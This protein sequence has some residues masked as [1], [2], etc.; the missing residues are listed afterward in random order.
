MVDSEFTRTRITLMPLSEQPPNWTGDMWKGIPSWAR[1]IFLLGFPA[2]CASWLIYLMS[3]AVTNELRD[4]RIKVE[5]QSL[6]ITKFLD[7]QTKQDTQR[8]QKLDILIRL[9][10]TS[11]VN[12]ATDVVQ[13]RNCLDAAIR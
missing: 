6:A 4:I 9:I 12:S 7:D 8:D 10:Q 5:T 2:V 3:G 1:A 13:R 11:C